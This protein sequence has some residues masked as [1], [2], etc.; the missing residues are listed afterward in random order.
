MFVPHQ[1]R[2]SAERV[3]FLYV[4]MAIEVG[5]SKSTVV[6]SDLAGPTYMCPICLG[7]WMSGPDVHS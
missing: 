1:G 7:E 2:A 6:V 5:H 4:L 3:G